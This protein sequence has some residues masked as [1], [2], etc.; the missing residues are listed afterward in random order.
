MDFMGVEPF[1][2]GWVCP[3]CGRVYSPTTPMCYY[4]GNAVTSNFTSRIVSPQED[5]KSSGNPPGVDEV[6]ICGGRDK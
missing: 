2:Q 3:K 6:T 4:C 1:N 5:K